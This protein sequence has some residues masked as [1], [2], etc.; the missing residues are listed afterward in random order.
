M[1]DFIV[2]MLATLLSTAIIGLWEILVIDPY[3]SHVSIFLERVLIAEFKIV[4]LTQNRGQVIRPAFCFGIFS[5]CAVTVIDIL[6][7]ICYTYV[8]KTSQMR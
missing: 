8:I 3:R 7:R 1:D 4:G 2:G 6:R 5:I